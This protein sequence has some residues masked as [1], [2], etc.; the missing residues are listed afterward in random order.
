MV[1]N[2]NGMP[3]SCITPRFTA[4]MICG[5]L[6]WQG[7]KS[8]WVLVMP[9]MGRSS[10]SS[11][12][13]MALIKALRRNSENSLSPYEVRPFL[14]P[15]SPLPVV[16]VMLSW[17]LF[18]FDLRFFGDA[19]PFVHFRLDAPGAVGRIQITRDHA[20]CFHARLGI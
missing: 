15:F 4:S 12:K 17:Q 10:A 18:E 7:L 14:K 8:L 2:T 3:P 13:P 6:P 19:G 1:G 20:L 16:R 11:V 9:M 5:T